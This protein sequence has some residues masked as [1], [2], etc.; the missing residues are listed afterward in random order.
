[1]ILRDHFFA[2]FRLS[3]AIALQRARFVRVSSLAGRIA[4]CP[5]GLSRHSICVMISIL[6]FMLLGR[7][8][9]SAR[10]PLF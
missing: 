6:I 1:M 10:R 2:I 9:L 5:D 4:A 7:R 8:A 3:S